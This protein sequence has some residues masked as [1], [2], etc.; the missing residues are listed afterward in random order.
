VSRPGISETLEALQRK[1]SN[2]ISVAALQLSLPKV[3]KT[4]RYSCK[5]PDIF[6]RC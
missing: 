4:L 6:V 3:W 1:H 2:E 5:V